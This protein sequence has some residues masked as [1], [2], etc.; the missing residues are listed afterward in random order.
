M[1]REVTDNLYIDLGYFTP[2]DY[3]VYEAS[4]EANFAS[5]ATFTCSADAGAVK[6]F[7][8]AITATATQTT[9]NTRVIDFVAPLGT[10]FS[11]TMNVNALRITEVTLIS[12]AYMTTDFVVNRSAAI[13]LSNIANVN[14]QAGKVNSASSQLNS[15]F[16]FDTSRWTGSGRPRNLNIV[17]TDVFES[18]IKKFGTH[19]LADN[20]TATNTTSS[21][22][23]PSTSQDWAVEW[24]AYNT[25]ATTTS[26]QQVDFDWLSGGYTNDRTAEFT[27]YDSSGNP[28]ITYSQASVVPYNTWCHFL[29]IKNSTRLSFYVNGTRIY[30]TT[31]LPTSYSNNNSISF[32]ASFSAAGDYLDEVSVWHNTT[33]GYNP[34]S[35]TITPPS[36]VRVNTENTVGLWHL[37]NNL[38]DDLSAITVSAS[39]TLTATATFTA[40]LTGPVKFTAQLNTAFTQTAQAEKVVFADAGLDTAFTQTAQA[41]RIKQ[42]DSGQDVS[43]TLTANV[44]RIA[45]FDAGL[46]TAFTQITTA[47]AIVDFDSGQ[48]VTATLSANNVRTRN[49]DS[50]LNTAFTFSATAV[51]ILDF[52]SGQDV[53]STLSVP[54]E[55]RLQGVISTDAVATQLTAAA[56]IG[57][58]LVTIESQF[59][60]STTANIVADVDAGLDVTATLA[61]D[62]IRTRDFDAGLDS[63]FTQ[64]TDIDVS[65]GAVVNLTA[66]FTQQTQGGLLVDFDSGLN[67]TTALTATAEKV[68]VAFSA[69]T[70]TTSL[71]ASA[72]I[73]RATTATLEAFATQLTAVGIVANKTA[74]LSATTA[75]TAQAQRTRTVTATL[76]A[77]ASQLTVGS[78]QSSAQAQLNSAFTLQC[79]AIEIRI[80]ADLTY[81]I[82][83]ETRTQMIAEDLRDDV[84][85]PELR[86]YT[87]VREIR[88]YSVSN[89]EETYII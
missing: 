67:T 41:T 21:S 33:L 83:A 63:A 84:V 36:T 61:A 16:R 87:I 57:N 1:T 46:D 20:R 60:Q 5:A 30:T 52:D 47:N 17:G 72:T 28:S 77:F 13:T 15:A 27:I 49:F 79:S 86:A 88:D 65:S 56:K 45:D 32:I 70:V 26:S 50:G 58:T 85:I 54:G 74:L 78:E 42:F 76:Q 51:L 18:T 10:A 12:N 66:Q 82:P 48:D 37:D 64:V 81:M 43:T 68:I 4:A 39:A 44:E 80:D 31:T 73:I 9:V 38:L 62:N 53:T 24:W 2:E 59:T 6:D 25:T 14:A 89:T 11:A 34:N 19:S 29:V 40:K 69:Q 22:T 75:L 7:S 35:S 55:R 8:V 71:T 23:R 3:Y